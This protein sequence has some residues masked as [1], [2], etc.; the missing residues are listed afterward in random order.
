M[1]AGLAFERA[2]VGRLATTPA[3]RNLITLFFLHENARKGPS[4]AT[5][6]AKIRKVGVVG[7]G[8]MGAGIAQLAAVKGYEVVVQEVNDAALAAGIQKIEA[9]FRKAAEHRVISPE[10]AEKKLSAIGRTTTWQGFADVDLAV[11]AAI[12]DL[13]A[14]RAIFCELER[15]TPPTAF[16]AT[17]TSS[18]LVEKLQEGREHPERIGGLH[19]FNPVHKMPLVE[20][21]HAPATYY[22]T[23][24]ALLQ[25]AVALGKTPVVVKD[26]PGFVVNRILMPYLN[27][28]VIILREGK[29]SV[30]QID[31]VMCRFGMPVGP[32]DLLDQVGLDIAAH[33]EAS[34]RPLLGDRFE[35]N[36]VFEQMCKRG[37]LGQ[38]KGLGFYRHQEGKKSEN[39]EAIL[40]IVNG[41]QGSVEFGTEDPGSDARDR[42]VLLMVNEAAACFCEGLAADAPSLD[43][44]VV[45]GTGWAPHRGGPLRYADDRGLGEIVR[46]LDAFSKKFGRR[47]EP[48]TE[49]RRRAEEGATFYGTALEEMQQAARLAA[50][51][52][53][54]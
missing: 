41:G 14:K 22:Q 10:E 4:P 43:L 9:L 34:M 36:P 49:L 26:S 1:D 24:T 39:D 33:I 44:A 53:P 8:T 46:V 42:M 6:A 21:V 17:N 29:L 5:E 19:F 51:A 52:S 3:C 20:V 7:A 23:L 37:W 32:L 48:C 2:A 40:S 54:G 18:L 47:F 25:F 28:A 27:E 38:K 11:E 31:R 45:F 35:P 30:K 12:E 13:D 50:V 15:H 16:L